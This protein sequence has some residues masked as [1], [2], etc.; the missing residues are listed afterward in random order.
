[1]VQWSPLRRVGPRLAPGE[2]LLGLQQPTHQ[3]LAHQVIESLA[4]GS[5]QSRS[6]SALVDTTRACALL[7]G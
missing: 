4:G 5:P 2:A 6:L 7:T 3:Q 1:L